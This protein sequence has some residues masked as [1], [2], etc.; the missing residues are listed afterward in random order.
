MQVTKRETRIIR[1]LLAYNDRPF[2]IFDSPSGDG[3]AVAA[4]FAP[5]LASTFR[6]LAG[7][8]FRLAEPRCPVRSQRAVGGAGDRVFGDAL[9]RREEARNEIAI[10]AGRGN[11]DR[12]TID[13][14]ELLHVRRHGSY[15]SLR[16]EDA[17][18]IASAEQQPGRCAERFEQLLVRNQ[19]RRRTGREVECIE[20]AIAI[21]DQLSAARFECHASV[22]YL[23]ANI[24]NDVRGSERGVAAEV[25]L[26][27]RSEPAEMKFPVFP[28]VKRGIGKIVFGGDGLKGRIREPLVERANGGGIPSEEL[29]REGVHV[30]DGNVHPLLSRE[31]WEACKRALIS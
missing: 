18:K 10:G 19:F 5:E 12:K 23:G 6:D 15:F 21:D 3:D 2:K 27:A 31:G 8:E 1:I 20:I 30:V 16:E 11:D 26:D 25:D 17:E 22:G 28:D 4:M 9:R 13:G 7:E 24:H 29:A 14:G